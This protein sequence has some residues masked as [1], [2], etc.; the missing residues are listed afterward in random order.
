MKT[1]ITIL[2]SLFCQLTFAQ[3]NN[4]LEAYWPLDGD[5]TDKSGKGYDGAFVGNITPATDRAGNLGCAVRIDTANSFFEYYRKNT[6]NNFLF[7]GNDATLCFWFKP[8]NIFRKSKSSLVR[9]VYNYTRNPLFNNFLFTT[10]TLDS[11][12]I[13]TNFNY[14]NTTSNFSLAKIW[15]FIVLRFTITN[16]SGGSNMDIFWNG[17]LM[18]SEN[19]MNFGGETYDSMLRF[20]ESYGTLLDDI[21]FYN[22][23][24]STE[25]IAA[26]YQLPSSC[27]TTSIETDLSTKDAR[28]IKGYYNLF[29]QEIN[30]IETYSGVYLIYYSDGSC[31]KILK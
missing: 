3:L 16:T 28:V 7:F 22:R 2:L 23:A 29:G 10:T 5:A 4:G 11:L 14:Q 19:N 21:R 26:L 8:D 9:H 25:E 15:N 27:S 17:Q 30:N 12:S 20:G 1:S 18:A 31:R 13:C 6:A 24:I